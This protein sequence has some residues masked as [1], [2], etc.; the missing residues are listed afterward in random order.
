MRKII[1]SVYLF[2]AGAASTFAFITTGPKQEGTTRV[3]GGPV[4]CPE[5]DPNCL[6]NPL[7]YTNLTD[8]L[9]GIAKFLLNL[10]VPVAA[11]IVIYGAFLILASAGNVEKVKQGKNAILYAAIGLGIMLLFRV[12]MALIANLL[13]TKIEFKQ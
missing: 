3:G 7:T 2:A 4:A 6:P 9:D 13:G 8:L 12:I 11:I 10:S 1:F 5:S